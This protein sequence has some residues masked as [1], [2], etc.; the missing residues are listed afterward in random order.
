MVTVY[1][2]NTAPGIYTLAQNGT[3][4]A[5]ILHSNYSEVT[6]T[7]PAVRGE[8]VQMFMTGLGPVT[9]GVADGVAAPSSPLSNSVEAADILVFLGSRAGQRLVRRPDARS[10][11]VI[12][13]QFHPAVERFDE[14]RC[15][16]CF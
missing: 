15:F 13:G 2:D 6:A 10:G 1:V 3:G 4:A 9:P 16:H 8:T 14:R 11:R 7:S 5:A 12:S